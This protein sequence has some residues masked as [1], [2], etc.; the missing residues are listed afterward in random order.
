MEELKPRSAIPEVDKWDLNKMVD[1]EADFEK[2]EKHLLQVLEKLATYKGR[3]T[4]DQDTFLEFWTLEEEAD[5]LLN[6]LYVYAHMLCDS[7]ST[8]SM[9]QRIKMRSEK[10]NEMAR[11]KTAY[12]SSE[13]LQADF[14][15]LCKWVKHEERF[16]LQKLFRYQDHVLNTREEELIAEAQNAFGTGSE[17]FYNIN[18][19]DVK[20]GT[21]TDDDGNTITVSNSNYSRLL[22][23][24]KQETRKLAFETLYQYYQDHKNTLAATLKGNMKEDFFTSKV[25]KFQSPLESSLFSDNIE[26]SVYTNLID[27]V[28]QHLP[29]MYRYM[30]IRKKMLGLEEMHM[31][32]IYVDL[33]KNKQEDIPF[34]EGKKIV[35]EALKPLGDDYLTDLSKAF[36]E[37]WIDKY[38]NI[39]KRSGAYKWGCYD[40]YPYVLLNYDDTIDSVSTMAH[41]LGHAMHSYYSNQNQD[42]LYHDYPIFLAEIASTVNEVILNDYLYHNAKTDEEKIYYLTSFLDK[43]KSTIYRQTMFA[44]FEKIMYEKEAKEIPLT[45]EEFSK[46]Y[47][48]LNQTYYG[49]EI[50]HDDAIRYEWARIPHF[51]TSFYVYKYATGLSSALSLASDILKGDE[52]ARKRYLEFLGSGCND[53]PLNILKKAGVDMTT[54]EPIEKALK[55]F[56]KKLN[57]LEVLERKIYGNH[58]STK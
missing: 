9:N 10:L 27:T 11:E 23:S 32:D 50:I 13:L 15:Q 22:N 25:H 48:E 3:L 4:Q 7:D 12:I 19:T 28:H 53:Y 20:F 56:E 33:V 24:K 44:E 42:Y 49:N 39:G 17:A 8:N 6:K 52:D 29:L 46:T 43:V 41:E 36:Q 55:M 5:R 2:E 18:N 40:S 57:E 16:H 14:E 37:L 51:Y 35:M 47:Y 1:G 31:Y 38:P 30:A 21:I 45:E 54:P 34:E 26:Q 58:Q